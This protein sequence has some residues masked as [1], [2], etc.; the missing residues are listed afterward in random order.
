MS[1]VVRQKKKYLKKPKIECV[2]A[3]QQPSAEPLPIISKSDIKQY[4][5]HSS[6][7]DEF[8]QVTLCYRVSACR[9]QEFQLP[10]IWPVQL[11]MA[12]GSVGQWR[13]VS[14]SLTDT[15]VNCEFG[16]CFREAPI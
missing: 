7:E 1:D 5:F 4:D 6:D 13:Y 8:P 9:R 15:C 2:V 11:G 14:M 16:F 10:V 3:A 12:N